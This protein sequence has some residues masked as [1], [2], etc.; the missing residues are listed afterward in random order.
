MLV[1][2]DRIVLFR[3]VVV[4]EAGLVQAGLV[5]E[6]DHSVE[7]GTEQPGQ[8][9]RVV[10]L[11]DD[12][13]EDQLVANGIHEDGPED[14]VVERMESIEEE[15][16]VQRPI[17]V[18]EDAPLHDAQL[19]LNVNVE[20]VVVGQL[21][22]ERM[23]LHVLDGLAQSQYPYRVQVVES[24]VLQ[25]LQWT[26]QMEF[27]QHW[28]TES[29]R[30]NFEYFVPLQLQLLQIGQ[31][32]ECIEKVFRVVVAHRN[33]VQ[34]ELLEMQI[35]AVEC[36]RVDAHQIGTIGDHNTS[37]ME[38]TKRVRVQHFECMIVDQ[39]QLIKLFGFITAL[40][41]EGNLLQCLLQSYFTETIAVEHDGVEAV[42]LQAPRLFDRRTFGVGWREVD[43]QQSCCEQHDHGRR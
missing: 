7:F 15:V 24:I 9:A 3:A 17:G 30:M 13:V 6:G 4:V 35:G 29:V 16:D 38:I 31:R 25:Q 11:L 36:V 26:V 18:G 14:G 34:F 27:G 40:K 22:V 21:Q 28:L 23:L 1:I 41:E 39:Q 10:H 19:A 12:A 20:R 5:L 32:V 33:A 2:V 42:H 8:L 37:K 43:D